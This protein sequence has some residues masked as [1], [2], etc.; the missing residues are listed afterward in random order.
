MKKYF[1]EIDLKT[2][3]KNPDAG[4]TFKY[5]PGK[6]QVSFETKE[7]PSFFINGENCVITE[8]TIDWDSDDIT[9]N[10]ICPVCG[11]W[12]CCKVEYETIEDALK[13]ISII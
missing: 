5:Y 3:E 11:K 8:H 4:S 1:I 13:K 12:D 10:T 6:M 9:S 2:I 7:L